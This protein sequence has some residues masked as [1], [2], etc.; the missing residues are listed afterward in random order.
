MTYIGFCKA[1]KELSTKANFRVTSWWRSPESNEK[2]GGVPNSWHLCG[3][4][5][6]IIP[7]SPTDKAII[8][9]Q[10]IPEG[11]EVIDEG[12]HLHIEPR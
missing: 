3:M 2:V 8:M 11:L 9:R 6:D 10:A 1:I 4:G 5:I 12:D 7:D